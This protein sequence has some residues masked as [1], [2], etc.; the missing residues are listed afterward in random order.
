MTSSEPSEPPKELDCAL[1]PLLLVDDDA[2]IHADFARVLTGGVVRSALDTLEEDLFGA[3]PG[4]SRSGYLLSHAYQGLEAVDLVRAS[5]QAA[6]PYAMAFIDARMPPGIDGVETIRRLWQIDAS[7]HVVLCTAYTDYSWHDLSRLI[8]PTDRLLILKKPFDPLEVRQLAS[9]LSHKARLVRAQALRVARLDQLVDERTRELHYANEQLREESLRREETQRAL[10]RT[11]RMEALGRLTAGIAHEIN[12]PLTI[13]RGNLDLL[14]ELHE[15]EDTKQIIEDAIHS[16]DR[17]ARI[18]HDVRLFASPQDF[19]TEPVDLV[20]VLD[21]SI[22]L[23]GKVFEHRATLVRQFQQVPRVL[24]IGPRLEQV[25][26]NLLGNALKAFPPSLER[27]PEVRLSLAVAGPDVAIEVADNGEG[28]LEDD[29]PRVFEPFFTT[30]EIGQ[31][32]GLGLAVSSGIV[33]SFGGRIEIR[34]RRGEGTVVR[35]LLPACPAAAE[36]PTG[37][38]DQRGASRPCLEVLVIDDEPAML[39]TMGRMLS[40]HRPTLCRSAAEALAVLATKQFDVIVC[41]VMMPHMDGMALFDHLRRASPSIADRMV[42]MTGG[43]F[44]DDTRAMLE[45]LTGRWIEKP[46]STRQLEDL[47]HACVERAR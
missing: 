17:I 12:N 34:S 16:T 29:L 33:A 8:G 35:V 13:V 27:S 42:F 1:E 11:Q 7:L 38:P 23:L 36:P 26:V 21:A 30:R 10:A 44:S 3:P 2:S 25:F 45:A 40:K 32:S 41:D 15:R 20:R 39:H 31:G 5:L 4:E 18:V 6:A 47:L 28:I 9:A 19:K 24:A 46:F 37:L 43:V 14:H 22:S